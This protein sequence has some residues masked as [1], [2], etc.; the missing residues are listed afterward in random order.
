M[1]PRR[2]YRRDL[3]HLYLVTCSQPRVPWAGNDS[4]GYKKT[5]LRPEEKWEYV[6]AATT[7]STPVV[8]DHAGITKAHAAP[9]SEAV[10]GDTMGAWHDP[11]GNVLQVLRLPSSKATTADVFDDL[12]R[13]EKWGVSLFT[14]L[15]RDK[16]TGDV[17]QL[18]VP[19]IGLT[20]DPAWGRVSVDDGPTEYDRGSWVRYWTQDPREL[21]QHLHTTYTQ[22]MSRVPKEFLQRLNDAV[23]THSEPP[24]R[25]SS[26]LVPDATCATKAPASA[27]PFPGFHSSAVSG[28]ATPD[29]AAPIAAAAAAPAPVASAPQPVAP[30]AE[31]MNYP[32][33]MQDTKRDL[34]E[35]KAIRNPSTRLEKIEKIQTGVRSLAQNATP[36]EWKELASI[37][38]DAHEV[39]T[40][41][42]TPVA[43]ELQALVEQG[44]IT[45]DAIPFFMTAQAERDHQGGRFMTD[46]VYAHAERSRDQRELERRIVSE[47]RD[48]KRKFDDTDAELQAAKKQ[49]A[50]DMKQIEQLETRLK[51]I[52]PKDIVAAPPTQAPVASAPAAVAFDSVAASR[53]TKSLWDTVRS[54]TRGTLGVIPAKGEV[55]TQSMITRHELADIDKRLESN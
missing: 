48:L 3:P 41:M 19:H 50:D 7:R 1:R 43:H 33:M 8:M 25:V 10:V 4:A 49:R 32:K 47:N 28:M 9:P 5:L 34:E 2:A 44:Y 38:A 40:S 17:A 35:L 51:N 22:V 45:P 20:K 54:R 11:V 21:Q 53:S 29:V 6:Q 26:P 27:T 30:P 31:K 52:G 24:P 14:N 23:A 36:A 55:K 39:H 13:G 42:T 16:E 46:M 37:L 15:G 12:E 18:S